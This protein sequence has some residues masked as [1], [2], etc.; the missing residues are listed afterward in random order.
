M[1]KLTIVSK[2][3]VFSGIV[4]CGIAEMV[5]SLA[6]ALSLDYCVSIV[7]PDGNGVYARGGGSFTTI[8]DGVRSCRFLNVDY[9]L[10][11][12]TIWSEK[13]ITIIN[14]IKPDILHNLAE[15][16]LIDALETRPAKAIY[17][18]DNTDIF[19]NKEQYISKYDSITTNSPRYAANVMRARSTVAGTLSS[20]DFS[21]VN[22]GIL[23]TVFA[24]EKGLFLASKYTSTNLDGKRLCKERLMQSYGIQEDK[25]I[26]LMM[27]RLVKEKNIEAV[28]DVLPIINAT[29]GILI[30]VGKGAQEYERM[31][32]QYTRAD[33]LIYI[34][35]WASPL[36]AAPLTA[37]ADFYIQP[38][39]N[40]SGGLMPMTACRYGTIPIVTQNGGLADNFNDD[41]A[42][43]V[44]DDDGGVECAVW[45]AVGLYADKDAFMNKRKICMEQ[46]FSWKTRKTGYI[47]LYEKE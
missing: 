39:T 10:I 9:Y 4:K 37:G 45:K 13:S 24:P 21:G 3:S 31:L 44:D 46:D 22:I 12:P 29:G 40:E 7:C 28:L 19:N 47:E 16:E 27:C 36:Q 35:R 20:T 25:C 42:I 2:E 34:N 1:K 6:N 15:P 5:D 30:V 17:T 18:F 11:E 33:G 32:K 23:D 41:N 26:Y 38:S 14:Q 43:I 8:E